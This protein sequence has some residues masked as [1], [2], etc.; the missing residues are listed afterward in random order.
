MIALTETQKELA[1]SGIEVA[2]KAVGR[3]MRYGRL[4]PSE[5]G[6]FRSYCYEA[7]C[8]AARRYRHDKDCKFTTYAGNRMKWVLTDYIRRKY[9]GSVN[10]V[11]LPEGFDLPADPEI[12]G[13]DSLIEVANLTKQEKRIAKL[14]LLHKSTKVASIISKKRSTI[15]WTRNKIVR[16]LK[17]AASIR[18]LTERDFVGYLV[19]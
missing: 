3:A 14:L 2:D 19:A 8:F 5:A 15:S 9:R 17:R 16:K 6:D 11:S 7:L 18:G 4:H 1:A 12:S 13:L 10:A